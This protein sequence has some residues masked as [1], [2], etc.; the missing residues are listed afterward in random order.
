MILMN[1]N[2]NP[3]NDTLAILN[4]GY[5]AKSRAE[6]AARAEAK[7]AAKQKARRIAN[8]RRVISTLNADTYKGMVYEICCTFKGTFSVSDLYPYGEVLAEQYP[9]FNRNSE[10]GDHI[11]TGIR[12]VLAQLSKWDSRVIR[13][14]YDTYK[15]P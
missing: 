13:V 12:S 11:M 6:E 8:A 15:L 10:H 9:N 4:A 7:R 5:T 14:A 1:Q 2:Q 3:I